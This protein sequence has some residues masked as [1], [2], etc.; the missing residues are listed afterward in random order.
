[1]SVGST[2]LRPANCHASLWIVIAA[3]NDA[4]TSPQRTPS[5]APVNPLRTELKPA[6]IAVVGIVAKV[7]INVPTVFLKC[8]TGLLNKILIHAS[9][10]AFVNFSHLLNSCAALNLCELPSGKAR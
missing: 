10:A 4:C 9:Y 8:V 1:M 5:V 2:K 7:V 6:A 3:N